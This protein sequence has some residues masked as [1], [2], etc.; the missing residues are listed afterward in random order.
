MPIYEKQGHR[1][2]RPVGLRQDRR[3]C[4]ASTACTTCYPGN[5]YEGAIMLHPGQHQPA[6][7]GRRSDRGAHA[8]RHGV[9]EAEPVSRSR[10]S[11]TSPTACACAASTQRTRARRQGR[12]GAARRGA[13][14]RGQ[15]PA[16]RARRSPSRAASSSACA[17][18]ARWRPSPEIL[19]FD[20]PTSALD[21]IA[22]ARIEELITELQGAG[23][24]PDR[25][26]QH[27]AG[28]A[29]VGLHRLHVPRRAGRVRRHR[30]RSSPSPR[31]RQTEDYITGR[32][33]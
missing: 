15:G 21:P 27:A 17:S 33:G 29:R 16:E 30:R 7:A 12:E 28:G 4:A 23:H 6:G 25:H 3:S 18:R 32:F 8:H 9:P 19:L 22:T 11:R 2:D 31:R 10:S 14:G 24:D 5:R 26:A 13:V 1:A 20:E